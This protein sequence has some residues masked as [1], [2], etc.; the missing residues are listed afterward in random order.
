MGLL[1]VSTLLECFTVTI[2]IFTYLLYSLQNIYSFWKKKGIKYATPL[3]L[4]GNAKDIALR[5]KSMGDVFRE[6]YESFPEDRYVGIFELVRPVLLVRDPELLK[7]FL[8]KDFHCFQVLIIFY[9]F[10]CRK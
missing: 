2:V 3:P 9:Y 8:V 1:M 7:Y 6:I 4:F 5:K 10:S